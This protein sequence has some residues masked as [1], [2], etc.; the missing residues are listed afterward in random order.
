MPQSQQRK[1]I[2]G[3]RYGRGKKGGRVG[4]RQKKSYEPAVRREGG[5]GW[6]RNRNIM[7]ESRTSRSMI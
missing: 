5:G 2:G 7:R 1:C 6:W 4:N 3:R